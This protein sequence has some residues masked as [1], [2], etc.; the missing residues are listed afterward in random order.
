[1]QRGVGPTTATVEGTVPSV[2]TA[3]LD[4][5]E[6]VLGIETEPADEAEWP[7]DWRKQ[8]R[9]ALAGVC[10]G[11]VSVGTLPTICCGTWQLL[12]DIYLCGS[13]VVPSLL[14][15]TDWPAL[16]TVLFSG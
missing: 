7:Y 14:L 2:D 12:R 6:Q 5:Q 13:S 4:G 16:R 1:M 9:V 8:L 10:V 15:G 11:S 3:D